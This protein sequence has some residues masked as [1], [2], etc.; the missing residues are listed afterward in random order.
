MCHRPGDLYRPGRYEDVDLCFRA[1]K[2]G[3]NGY[4]V[5]ASDQHHEGGTSFG[6]VFG[7]EETK[8]MVFRN[9]HLFMVKNIRD[10]FWLARCFFFL[11]I[12]FFIGLLLP[13][14]RFM[15]KGARNFLVRLPQAIAKRK[16]QKKEKFVRTDREVVAM[17][18][19]AENGF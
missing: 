17:L 16:E 8:S 13:K 9:A 6:R 3:W 1:W 7:S 4:Y 12:K 15:A 5:P 19:G 18:T 10:P 11:F 2:K 14:Y